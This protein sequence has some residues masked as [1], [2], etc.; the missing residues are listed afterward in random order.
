MKLK[1]CFLS[2]FCLVG[3]AHAAECYTNECYAAAAAAAAAEGAASWKALEEEDTRMMQQQQQQQ[4]QQRQRLSSDDQMALAAAGGVILA[5]AIIKGLGKALFSPPSGY[6]SSYASSGYSASPSNRGKT[7]TCKVY[8]VSPSGSLKYQLSASSQQEA[9]RLVDS[10]SYDI[11]RSG[12]YGGD[13]PQPLSS[14]QC[15]EQ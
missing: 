14:Q 4:Q 3:N 12:G 2:V 15:S 5:G 7:F 11:C 8:C 10:N 9:V 13:H 6:S 1:I